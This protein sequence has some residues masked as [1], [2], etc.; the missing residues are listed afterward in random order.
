LTLINDSSM[1]T[2]EAILGKNSYQSILDSRKKLPAVVAPIKTF[3]HIY[4]YI[5]SYYYLTS[6]VY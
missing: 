1:R 2:D 5:K 3:Q 4:I 6:L